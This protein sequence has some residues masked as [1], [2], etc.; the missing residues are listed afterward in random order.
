H[1]EHGRVFNHGLTDVDWAALAT[2]ALGEAQRKILWPRLR[3]EKKFYFGGM[4]TAIATEPDT[5]AAWEYD[6]D[7]HDLASMG[8]VWYLECWARAN[9]RDGEGIVES[10][11]RVATAGKKNGWY[12]RERYLPGEDGTFPAKGPNTYCEYPANLIRVVH[13]F[14]F[15]VEFGLDGVLT[16]APAAPA[17]YYR[18]GFGQTVEWRGGTLEFRVHSKG[19]SGRYSGR[20]PLRVRARIGEK[21][22]KKELPAG[23]GG[24]FEWRG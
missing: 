20:D 17:S 2:P 1:P 24:V 23:R 18:A 19:I 5:Y 10:L 11:R 12:W 21:W 8:R 6:K 22:E 3:A 7:H 13:R 14:L 16:I 9:F 15:G 4:P